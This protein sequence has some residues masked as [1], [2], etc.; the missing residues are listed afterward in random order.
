MVGMG[1]G[2][3]RVPRIKFVAIS[4]DGSASAELGPTWPTTHRLPSMQ[5]V[6]V[7]CAFLA[8]FVVSDSL[9]IH[10]VL[11]FSSFRFGQPVCRFFF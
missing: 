4:R 7:F 8:S 9:R 6:D 2:H 3:E 10:V 5:T 1:E 11:S